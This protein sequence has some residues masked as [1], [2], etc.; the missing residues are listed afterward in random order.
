MQTT[1]KLDDVLL[2]EFAKRFFGYGAHS[3][4][5]WFVGIEE[6]GGDSFNEV[7]ARLKAWSRR[8]GMELED[9]GEFCKEIGQ[10]HWF[11]PK[12]RLQSTWSKYIR[13]ILGTK[14]IEAATERVRDYQAESLG[15]WNGESCMMNLLPLPSP[16]GKHWNYTDWSD[17]QRLASRDSYIGYYAPRRAE[18]IR[19]QLHQGRP[20]A[21]LFASVSPEY[22]RWWQVIAGVKFEALN[23]ADRPCY[24]GSND[25][26]VFVVSQHPATRGITNEYF[27]AIGKYMSEHAR[28]QEE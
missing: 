7:E 13:V 24:V 25:S 19:N 5:H 8:G 22:R 2:K 26:T 4:D 11:R 16:S 21:V 23:L 3:G 20:R 18:H 15:R 27:R 12:A 14:S 17:N 9:V 1:S 10:H 6:G 28:S